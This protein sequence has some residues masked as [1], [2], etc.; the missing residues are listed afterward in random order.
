MSEHQ[1]PTRPPGPDLA[2]QVTEGLAEAER[3]NIATAAIF[4]SPPGLSLAIGI[5]PHDYDWS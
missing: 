2:E 4:T 3:H 5:D 1:P